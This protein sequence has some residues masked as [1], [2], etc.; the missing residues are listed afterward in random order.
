MKK[1]TLLN[2]KVP[3]LEKVKR[4]LGTLESQAS[5]SMKNAINK[6]LKETSTLM[7]KAVKENY[8]AKVADIKKTISIRKS[9]V[10]DLSGE[11]I[12]KSNK[13]IPLKGFSTNP[14]KPVPLNTKYTKAKVKKKN[15]RKALPGK[16]NKSSAF[17]A[18][19]SN[20]HIGVYQRIIGKE[21]SKATS[22]TKNR[23][24]S[25][26]A[27]KED[28]AIAELFGMPVPYMIG[29]KKV[30]KKIRK[31]AQI[32]LEKTLDSEIKKIRDKG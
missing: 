29:E 10:K 8:T 3:D 2:I 5:K 24:N 12:S 30:A 26:W 15:S 31:E 32:F 22:R 19:M 9:K 20:G 25:I 7:V 1:D 16:G 18:K 27:G 14:S 6:T 23:E 28:Y 21:V 11:V 13:R 4:K 17:V